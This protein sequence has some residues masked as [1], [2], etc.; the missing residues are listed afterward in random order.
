MQHNFV[1]LEKSG[2]DSRVT[3]LLSGM[4]KCCNFDEIE[5]IKVASDHSMISIL[6][7]W[8]ELKSYH[9]YSI[10]AGTDV[11]FLKLQ[12]S[13]R[14]IFTSNIKQS[15]QNG[16]VCNGRVLKMIQDLDFECLKLEPLNEISI[17]EVPQCSKQYIHLSMNSFMGRNNEFCIIFFQTYFYD[18]CHLI[19]SNDWSMVWSWC[20]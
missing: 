5:E 2:N 14:S 3:Y 20:I 6:S 15:I 8:K 10:Q 19:N 18:H 17:P 16:S 13:Q 1:I 12:D 4:P 11:D 9:V 7:Q